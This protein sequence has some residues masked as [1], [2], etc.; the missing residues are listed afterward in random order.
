M[1]MWPSGIRTP[2]DMKGG[3]S[4]PLDESTMETGDDAARPVFSRPRQRPWQ[5][6]WVD[7][8]FSEYEML[9]AFQEEQRASVFLFVHPRTGE[10]WEC[11]F[12]SDPITFD[13]G[14]TEYMSVTCTLQPVRKVY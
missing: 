3:I 8:P 6:S 12:K 11:R 7:M 5:L 2:S 1:D 10:A 14:A 13:E 4:D 9:T